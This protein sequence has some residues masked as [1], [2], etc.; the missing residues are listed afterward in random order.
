[1]IYVKTC[2]FVL[3]GLV[4][5][6]GGSWWFI[7]VFCGY[8]WFLTHNDMSGSGVWMGLE[9]GVRG[10]QW[11]L[12]SHSVLQGILGHIYR[13]RGPKDLI[14]C[15]LY[16]HMRGSNT[17]K[18]VR[19]VMPE[20]YF[21]HPIPYFTRYEIGLHWD[22]LIRT[23]TSDGTAHGERKGRINVDYYALLCL[24]LTASMENISWGG[25]WAG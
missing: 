14:R 7:V 19:T 8:C 23:K 11:L 1:M 20:R 12:R 6:H 24:L 5:T 18:R 10:S 3:T 9:G 13:K 22:S 21:T 17:G 25:E 16:T 15:Y 2:W 4:M